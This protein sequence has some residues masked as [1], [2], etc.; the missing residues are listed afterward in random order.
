M[1]GTIS[2]IAKWV[3]MSSADYYTMFIKAWI[4]YNAWYMT[5]YYDEDENRTSDRDIIYH[6]MTTGNPYRD[7]V[8]TL[9]N[10]SGDKSAEFKLRLAN[11]YQNL[12]NHPLPNVVEKMSFSRIN[13]LNNPDVKSTYQETVGKFTCR[14]RYD[15]TLPKKSPRWIL[16]VIKNSDGQTTNIIAL[17]KCSDLELS[18]APQFQE[19]PRDD[20]KD[21]L[22]RCLNRISPNMTSSVL[23]PKNG[24]T[25][26]PSD[27]YVVDPLRHIFFIDNKDYIA[28]AVIKVLYELRCKLFHGEI[29]PSKAHLETYEQAYYIQR[30]LN[31]T[32]V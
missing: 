29:E 3:E 32:L 10:G 22:R 19:I 14:A 9:L 23:H 27:C 11:L 16:E 26:V 4:P 24:N 30:L 25:R 20:I 17:H 12:E 6:I 8:L 1:P 18:N 31:E 5:N 2:N 21:T 28:R 13:I 15:N 7:R